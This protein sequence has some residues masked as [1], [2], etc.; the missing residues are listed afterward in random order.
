MFYS[1]SGSWGVG[2]NP[3]H[4][5]DELKKRNMLDRLPVYCYANTQT[6]KFTVLG[7]L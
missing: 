3:K 1:Y 5:F 7:N 4:A 6:K 2:A